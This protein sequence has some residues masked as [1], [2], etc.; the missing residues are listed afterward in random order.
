MNY[1]TEHTYTHL[2]GN[3]SG[4][5]TFG[6]EDLCKQCQLNYEHKY[7]FSGIYS[8]HPVS[9][10]YD[11]VIPGPKPFDNCLT[12]CTQGYGKLLEK[13]A[14]LVEVVTSPSTHFYGVGQYYQDLVRSSKQ[15]IIP[16]DSYGP[17]IY[18]LVLE[19]CICRHIPRKSF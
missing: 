12:R 11:Y 10:T 3:V 8:G 16:S 17:N 9:G 2:D 13:E 18:S 7:A 5:I 14:D 4:V 19:F 1:L 6:T 15:A